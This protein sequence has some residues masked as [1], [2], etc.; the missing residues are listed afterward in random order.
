M[1]LS[2]AK[3][4]GQAEHRKA[5]LLPKTLNSFSGFVWLAQILRTFTFCGELL[6]INGI[7][8]NPWIEPQECRRFY[9]YH[10]VGP[11]TLPFIGP[12]PLQYPADLH[13]ILSVPPPSSGIGPLNLLLQ[14]LYFGLSDISVYC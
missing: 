5:E 3:R 10:D 12:V 7:A 1:V 11:L 14:R 4:E 2:G 8:R 13:A 9:I 6:R